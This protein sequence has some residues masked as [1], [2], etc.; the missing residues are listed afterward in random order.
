MFEQT[1]TIPHTLFFWHADV[2][3]FM[4][5]PGPFRMSGVLNI[6]TFLVWLS[7]V[8]F[9]YCSW[10]FLLSCRQLGFSQHDS[11]WFDEIFGLD[12]VG[13]REAFGLSLSS[14][15]LSV[16]T[17]LIYVIS[18]VVFGSLI[19][20][21]AFLLFLYFFC[22]LLACFLFSVLMGMSSGAGTFWVWWFAVYIFLFELVAPR[23]QRLP[24][25]RAF[26]CD[27]FKRRCRDSL[28][29]SW[30]RHRV[31]CVDT[32]WCSLR[33]TRCRPAERVH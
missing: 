17:R 7:W 10:G 21:T 14:G 1:L 8:F 9:A 29:W 3:W 31:W 18:F 16:R 25:S 20:T 4:H 26:R 15:V 27:A 12:N 11:E 24:E 6:Q 2:D 13:T 5:T 19:A 30:S 32:V 28:W 33:R 22:Y 23:L